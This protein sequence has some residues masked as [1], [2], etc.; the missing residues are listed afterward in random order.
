MPG[1]MFA[2]STANDQTSANRPGGNLLNPLKISKEMGSSVDKVIKTPIDSI[3]AM[4][5][6]MKRTV[7]KNALS[8]SIG[9]KKA[10][11]PPNNMPGGHGFVNP[12]LA[13][14]K[15]HVKQGPSSMPKVGAHSNQQK[16]PSQ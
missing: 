1:D 9:K 6:T 5:K 13:S 12:S 15:N 8:K 16:G 3:D 7:L 14:T 2:R 11:M 4:D 10:K